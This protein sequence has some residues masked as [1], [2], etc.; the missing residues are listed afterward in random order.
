MDLDG[1]PT[2]EELKIISEWDIVK[3]GV[4]GLIDYIR[5]RWLYADC[6]F[7]DLKGKKVLRLRLS[8]A[9]WSGNE[10]IVGALKNNFIFW[11]LYWIKSE[12]GGHYW[13]RIK[14]ST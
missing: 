2:R 6:G 12:R 4:S 3:K 11:T 9:G 5:D 13:F 1:Y 14:L 7:F 10:T 8:T